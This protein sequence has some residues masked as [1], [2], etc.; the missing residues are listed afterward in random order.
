MARVRGL[1]AVILLSSLIAGCSVSGH[2]GAVPTAL[3]SEGDAR[4]SQSGPVFR[5]EV[6]HSR[7]FRAS[8]A[9]NSSGVRVKGIRVAGKRRDY[10]FADDARISQYRQYVIARGYGRTLVFQKSDVHLVQ[11]ETDK[12][13]VDFPEEHG[14]PVAS[15]LAS[16]HLRPTAATA[17]CRDCVQL[18]PPTNSATLDYS[19]RRRPSLVLHPVYCD[20]AL[21]GSCDSCGA[22]DFFV[23]TCCDIMSDPTCGSSGYYDSGGNWV[24]DPCAEFLADALT[25]AQCASYNALY[26]VAFIPRMTSF[27]SL[28]VEYYNWYFDAYTFMQVKTPPLSGLVRYTYDWSMNDVFRGRSFL[29]DVPIFVATTPLTQWCFFHS[30]TSAFTSTTLTIKDPNKLEV[31]AFSATFGAITGVTSPS[32]CLPPPS[33]V[34]V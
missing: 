25:Y 20:S 18:V 4:V 14:V 9:V 23:T 12:E 16:G 7:R 11:N 28:G 15:S 29:Q 33:D 2:P 31:G 10:W 5:I 13:L 1:S 3:H 8:E 30:D 22:N 24:A 27:K 17:A 32:G 6:N 26:P 19:S 21:E 34:Q